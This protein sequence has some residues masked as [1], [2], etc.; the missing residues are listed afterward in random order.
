MADS[1]PRIRI[2]VPQRTVSG[3]LD[4]KFDTD[5]YDVKLHG[6]LGPEQYTEAIEN[7]N[8]KLRKNRAG[9]VDGVLLASGSLLVF[10]LAIWGLRH[11][12]RTKK[13][14]QLLKEGIHEF[15]MRYPELM[16]RWNRHHNRVSPSRHALGA[17]QTHKWWRHE[18]CPMSIT[19]KL[20]SNNILRSNIHHHSNNNSHINHPLICFLSCFLRSEGIFSFY[21]HKM[22]HYY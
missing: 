20:H 15:N 2:I 10:P 1:G 6:L 17:I 7:L 12:K 3:G 5:P 22:V 8:E 11:Q 14:K 4:S 16:M 13:R 19:N 9:K 21:L 18:C